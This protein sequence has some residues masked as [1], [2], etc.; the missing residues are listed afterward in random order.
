[1][2][3]PLAL[4]SAPSA[5][6]VCGFRGRF[7]SEAQKQAGLFGYRGAMYPWQTDTHDGSGATVGGSAWSEQHITLDVAL[8]V[9]ATARAL[10]DMSF[11]LNTAFPVLSEVATWLLSRGTWTERGFEVLDMGGPDELTPK[12]DNAVRYHQAIGI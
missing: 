10:N 12:V 2:V 1:M 6:A 7:L 5:A 8:G 11:N 9:W 3:P 4:L